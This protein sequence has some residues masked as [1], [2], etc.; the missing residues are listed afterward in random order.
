MQNL[1]Q[2]ILTTAPSIGIG[3]TIAGYKVLA[4]RIPV[5]ARKFAEKH[6]KLRRGQS[7]GYTERVNVA[8]EEAFR[9]TFPE[10][11]RQGIKIDPRLFDIDETLLTQPGLAGGLARRF[12]SVD[13]LNKAIMQPF[14]HSEMSNQIISFYGGKRAIRN[15]MRTGEYAGFAGFDGMSPRQ[16]DEMLNFEAGLIVNATQFRPGAGSRSL[17]QGMLPAPARMFTSFP[18]RLGSFFVNSTVR[19]AMTNKQI[20]QSSVLNVLSGGPEGELAR[21]K[22]MSLGTGRN[23]GTIARSYL[24]GKIATE[25]ASQTLDVDLSGSLGITSGF[26]VAPDG[27]PFAPLPL[28][29]AAGVLYGVLSAAHSRDIKDLQPLHLPGI[30]PVMFPKTLMPGGV[31]VSRA[32]RAVQQFKPDM[33]GFVDDDERLMYAADTGDLLL[34][35]LGI[36]LDKNRRS[37]EAMERTQGVRS[38]IRSIRRQYATAKINYDYDT[39]ARL[40]AQWAKAFPG[41]P[42]LRLENRDLK[43]Y[44][45][46]AKMPAVHRMIRTM[47]QSGQFMERHIME[48]DPD[49]LSN[50]GF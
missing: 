4:D 17:V 15:S 8:L 25:G 23:F 24:Y 5:Y 39:Q 13:T 40:E 19:G 31:A 43:R 18:T 42:P 30:G 1:L 45:D 49:L 26:N 10:L 28:P 6:R 16:I 9:D 34:A 22:V 12:S 33:G 7:I 27:Q 2:P 44:R 20:Q 47:G 14:T 21:R 32:V 35:T 46:Q 11:A 36:P 29:P 3:P 41:Q 50:P 37:R 38:S 48:F